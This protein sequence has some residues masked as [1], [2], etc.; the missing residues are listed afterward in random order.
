MKKPY[1]NCIY[2]PDGQEVCSTCIRKLGMTKEEY[3]RK[4]VQE[5]QD[6]EDEEVEY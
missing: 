6:L 1:V 2:C 5:V 4:C 3:I